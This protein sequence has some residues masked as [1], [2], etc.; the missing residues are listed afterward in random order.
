RTTALCAITSSHTL[1]QPKPNARRCRVS[2]DAFGKPKINRVK[3]S[4]LRPQVVLTIRKMSKNSDF[5][6]ESLDN[7]PKIRIRLHALSNINNDFSIFDWQFK[8]SYLKRALRNA[9]TK[10]EER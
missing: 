1:N 10:K 2:T 4:T 6:L 7:Q 8:C 5:S 9:I 3:L